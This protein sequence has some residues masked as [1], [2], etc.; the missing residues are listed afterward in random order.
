MNG[1]GLVWLVYNFGMEI[2]S[3]TTL[4]ELQEYIAQVCVERGF[5]MDS[6]SNKMVMLMEE[7]GELA[8]AVRKNIGMKFDKTTSRKDVAEEMA[9]VLIVLVGLASILKI[10]LAEALENKEVKN[11]ERNWE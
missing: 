3:E 7:V 8:K 11:R 6:P 9:D 5:D 1:L 2:S 10:D 4:K